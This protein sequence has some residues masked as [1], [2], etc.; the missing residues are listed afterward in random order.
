MSTLLYDPRVIDASTLTPKASADIYLPVGVE[1]QADTTG[2]ATVGTPYVI[3]RVDDAVTRF[4]TVALSPLTRMVKALL[5]RGAGPVTAI[6]SSK[7]AGPTL[8][9][10]QAA[11]AKFEA[12][13]NIRIRLTDSELQADLTALATSAAN[14]DLLY[15]KQ[16]AFVGLPS[17]TAKS[18]LI[19]G[20]TA[21]Q[22]AGIPAATRTVLVGPGVYDEAGTLRGGS[23]AAAVV[24]A[25]AAK[26]S[27]P[28][29]DLDLW[30][31][32]YTSGIELG[33]D[34]RAVFQRS[35]VAGVAVND[36]E[37]LQQAGISALQPARAPA[38]GAATTH[39][40]TVYIAN[41]TYDNF[42]TRIIVDQ[43]F[44]D[45]KN[46]IL[47]KN[48]L[49]AGNTDRTRNQI[50]SGVSALLEARASWIRPVTQ[51]DT[52]LG[53]NVTVTSSNDNR[54][55]TIGYEGIVVRGISTV[56]VAANLSIP[57]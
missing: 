7:T 4:G 46:Y 48:F 41:T 45:V 3:S 27:D 53:Y 31:I 14:A 18:A 49:R 47:D 44:I 21:L 26:N 55:V 33:T 34:G 2:T 8:I 23:F 22:A 51:P 6:A 54:Q 13:E 1:G 19:T 5:D 50:K 35:V 29:N 37:D 43:V 10:R 17:G 15:N 11:W 56:R 32:P 40:R 20:A 25:E 24:A 9:Q 39:I 12:D 38:I 16:V 57:A 28:A 52:S 30:T 36:Y 42:Y